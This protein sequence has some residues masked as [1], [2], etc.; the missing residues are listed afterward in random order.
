ME[1]TSIT[2]LKTGMNTEEPKCKL[3]DF[4]EI[5]TIIKTDSIPVDV[6]VQELHKSLSKWNIPTTNIRIGKQRLKSKTLRYA[7]IK[8][9]D[10]NSNRSQLL[11]QKIIDIRE[12]IYKFY[13]ISTKTTTDT[14]SLK[15]YTEQEHEVHAKTATDIKTNN[16]DFP[17][18][19]T[20][21]RKGKE[22]QWNDNPQPNQVI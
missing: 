12:K 17:K 3:N 8:I 18:Y 21:Q 14:K 20:K 7:T 16:T 11:S 22:K 1:K 9:D 2:V 15:Q 19:Q 5:T 6:T 10:N 13:S 4:Y